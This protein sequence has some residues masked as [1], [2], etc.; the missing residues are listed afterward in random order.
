MEEKAYLLKE[1]ELQYNYRLEDGET[2]SKVKHLVNDL[3]K[4]IKGSISCECDGFH[5]LGFSDEEVKALIKQYVE[6]Q[7]KNLIK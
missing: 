1:I 5:S 2:Y 4:S 7:P 6:S 3:F